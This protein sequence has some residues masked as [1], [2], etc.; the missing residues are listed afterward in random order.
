[1]GEREPTG[2]ADKLLTGFTLWPNKVAALER[3][4]PKYLARMIFVCVTEE[5]KW[6]PQAE[7]DR[8]SSSKLV[9]LFNTSQEGT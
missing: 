7:C 6:P 5:E 3:A 8:L 4:W 9:G 2:L 1:L